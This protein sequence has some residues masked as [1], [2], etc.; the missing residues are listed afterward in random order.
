MIAALLGL[1]AAALGVCVGWAVRRCDPA[2]TP[3]PAPRA[4]E[5]WF[6]SMWDQA[7]EAV[8]VFDSAMRIGF[9][10]A[11]VEAL[12]G[13]APSGLVGKSV[14][15]LVP[16]RLRDALAQNVTCAQRSGVRL[17][18]HSAEGA[19]LH[20]DGREVSIEI[21][22]RQLE[23]DG[24]SQFAAYFRDVSARSRA[25]QVLRTSE[26]R[27][28]ERSTR[29]AWRCGTSTCRAARSTSRNRGHR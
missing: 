11:A 12:L 29:R 20:R 19:G 24:A 18:W 8:V 3:A 6:R 9:A 21:A 23:V 16:L 7:P 2:P 4:S 17:D 26:E 22:L 28:S 10:N 27:L 5:A 15:S 13:H 25:E 1:L 14:S